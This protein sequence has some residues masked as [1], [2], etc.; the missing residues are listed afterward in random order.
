MS[1]QHLGCCCPPDNPGGSCDASCF[2]SSYILSGVSGTYHYER[3]IPTAL[4]ETCACPIG[5]SRSILTEWFVD[6]S[7]SQNATE[8]LTRLGSG[9][10]CYG[11]RGELTVSANVR[12]VQYSWCC[13]SQEYEINDQSFQTTEIEVPFCFTMQCLTNATATCGRTIAGP[14]RWTIS[15]SICDFPLVGTANFIQP[16]P[17]PLNCPSVG[18]TAHGLH[19][20]GAV[21]TKL[22]KL[23]AP[24][25]LLFNETADTTAGNPALNCTGAQ[26]PDPVPTSCADT[27]PDDAQCMPGAVWSSFN[28]GNFAV[29]LIDEYDPDQDKPEPCSR[30]CLGFPYVSS[31]LAFVTSGATLLPCHNVEANWSDLVCDYGAIRSGGWSFEIG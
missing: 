30:R 3:T 16:D 17:N 2:A 14:D 8:T 15:L 28:H 7:F 20:G 13:Q 27:D 19:I 6:V 31:A 10:C 22:A 5:I 21:F 11:A 26:I 25:I 24:D 9:Q 12:I 18:T 23:K 4:E 1:T 29:W